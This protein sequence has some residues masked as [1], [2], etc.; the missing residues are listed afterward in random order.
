MDEVNSIMEEVK[1][2]VEERKYEIQSHRVYIPKP[3]SNKFR[4]LGVP[5][6][7]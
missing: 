7:S 3:G 5:T 2:I 4:P 1:H 6:L